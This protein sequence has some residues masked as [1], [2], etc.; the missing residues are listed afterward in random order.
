MTVQPEATVDYGSRFRGR[1]EGCLETTVE[2]QALHRE[3]QGDD[4]R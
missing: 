3:T 2:L 1:H 4:A